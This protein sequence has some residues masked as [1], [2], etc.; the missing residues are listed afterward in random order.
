[1][2]IKK[3]FVVTFAIAT[4]LTGC[5]TSRGVLDLKVPDLPNPASSQAVK[6]MDVTDKRVFEIEPKK[7]SIPSLQNDEINDPKITRRA[8]ARKRNG[9]GAALGDILLP[10]GQTVEQLTRAALENALRGV[11]FGIGC[12]R[13]AIALKQGRERRATDAHTGLLEQLTPP[14]RAQPVT[15]R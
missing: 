7:P 4:I 11:V 1:M 12:R 5:A 15:F 8:V 3:K 13:S 14:H 6:I 9:F 2:L 10:E